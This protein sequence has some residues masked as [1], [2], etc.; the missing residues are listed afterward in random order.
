MVVVAVLQERNIYGDDA[1]ASRR[2]WMP[3]V[4]VIG[5]IKAKGNIA[6]AIAGTAVTM[7][8]CS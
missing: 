5:I 2:R 4:I 3:Q 8:F 6:R 7:L 1:D